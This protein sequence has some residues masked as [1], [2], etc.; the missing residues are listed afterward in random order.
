LRSI[1]VLAAV[2]LWAGCAAPPPPPPPPTIVNV[3]LQASPDVNGA[4][5]GAGA[6][7]VLRVYQL[8]SPAGFSNGEFFQLYNTDSA[9]LGSD[10]VKRD[11]VP[12]TPGQ[13]RS[14]KLSPLETV[15]ALGIFGGYR[16]FQHVTWRGTAD[17]AAHQTTNVTVTAG[18]TGLTVQAAP[19]L[20]ATVPPAASAKTGP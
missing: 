16:D 19:A 10:L 13:S 15:H 9:T 4:P 8:A 6:P 7:I 11:D 20:P 2:V 1:T 12:L 14:L 18:G 5:G 3:T 17:I